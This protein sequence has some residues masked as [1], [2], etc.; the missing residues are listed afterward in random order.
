MNMVEWLNFLWDQIR[1][2]DLLQWVGVTFAV[3]EVLLARRNNILLYPAG[4]VSVSVTMYIFYHSGLYAESALNLYYFVMSLY[5][6]WY[7]RKRKGGVEAVRVGYAGREDWLVT[8]GIVTAGFLLTWYVLENHTTS[9]VAAW[10]AWVAATAW[11][12]MWLL[13]RRKIENWILLNVSNAFAVPLLFHKQLPMY[14]VLTL[15]LFAV[16]VQGFFRWKKLFESQ[17]Q[18]S[19]LEA[20]SGA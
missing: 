1:E 14:S 6:W 16:A 20:S 10:D 11:A 9:T 2:T 4:L 3:A 17:Q 7:W 15:F 13:A 12:G 18:L 8:A 19:E 5:G